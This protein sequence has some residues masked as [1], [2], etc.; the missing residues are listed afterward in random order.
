[1]PEVALGTLAES[2]FQQISAAVAV[3]PWHAY[4]LIFLALLLENLFPPV[5]TELV[6]PLAGF[7]VAQQKLALPLVLLAGLAGTVL[8]SLFWY[9]VG[10]LVNEERLEHWLARRGRFLG[11]APGHLATSR[12]W[13][14]R[15]GGA[16]VFWGRMVPGIRP[17]VSLPA[18]IELMPVLP[19]LLW[20]S[21]GSMVWVA[22]LTWAGAVLGD[23]YTLVLQGLRVFASVVRDGAL[24]LLAA[25]LAW[26][27]LRLY[28]HW[29]RHRL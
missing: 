3:N 13:F 11:L 16:V 28:R 27:A 4:G 10:R 19:F 23:N 29:R 24:L 12:R 7:L 14:A 8:G 26:G 20:T 9:G 22:A 25:L 15:H 6:M 2:L 5:P 1:M 21:A 18:G 17:F